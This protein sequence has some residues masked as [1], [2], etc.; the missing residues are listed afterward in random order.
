MAMDNKSLWRA[1]PQVLL[2]LIIITVGVLFT[3]DNLNIIYAEDYLR[4]WP[5]LLVI[6]GISK[7]AQP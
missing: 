1:T 6:Y 5:A 2:G 3:L 4:Y 7:M